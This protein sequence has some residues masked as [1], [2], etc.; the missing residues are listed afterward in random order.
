M[1]LLK[2]EQKF[3]VFWYAENMFFNLEGNQYEP[4]ILLNP[5]M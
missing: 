2:V 5:V 1:M 4:T 3:R